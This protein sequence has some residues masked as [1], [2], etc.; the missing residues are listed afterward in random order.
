[1]KLLRRPEGHRVAATSWLRAAVLGANDGIVSTA[2]LVLGVAGA[3]ASQSGV[4]VAGVAGLVAGALSMAV[5]E[6]VSVSSQL[7]AERADL[8][9][10]R[11]EH[12]ESPEQELEELR[13]IY[14]RKGLSPELAAEVAVQLHEHGDP[15]EIHAREELNIDPEALARPVQ[16]AVVS[17]LAFSLGA[18]LPILAIALTGAAS[19]IPL[20]FCAA[21][22]AL[23][24]LGGWSAWLG[25]APV[26]R[27]VLRSVVGGTLAMGITWGVGRLFAVTL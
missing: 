12:R 27:A 4:L 26:W 18:A 3:E 24:I 6:Y 14:V 8:R 20:T 1:M 22:L 23:S 17:A 11:K 7:E 13:Q 16:A 10:E 9:L 25:G 5:G 15:L 19:R 21:L 2:S